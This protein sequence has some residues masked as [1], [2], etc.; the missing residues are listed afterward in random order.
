MIV[1]FRLLPVIDLLSVNANYHRICY[2]NFM[3]N[4]NIPQETQTVDPNNKRVKVGRKV[5]DV[6]KAAFFEVVEYLEIHMD[7]QLTIRELIQMMGGKLKETDSEPYSYKYFKSKLNEHFKN[8]ILFTNLHGKVN[9]IT[10]K[11]KVSN[12]LHENFKQTEN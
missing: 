10:H 3:I 5:D 12:V 2:V 6:A 8:N 1:E 9:V 4:K 7:E 11:T